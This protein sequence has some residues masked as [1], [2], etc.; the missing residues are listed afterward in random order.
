KLYSYFCLTRVTEKGTYGILTLC[1]FPIIEKAKYD[2]SFRNDI[3]PRGVSRI[4]AEIGGHGLLHVY[5]IHLG[6][7]VRERRHQ[8]RLMLSES[9]LLDQHRQDPKIIMGDFND[10]IVSVVHGK[11]RRHF[12]DIFNYLQ[13]KKRSTF[14]WRKI[15]MRLDH[16]YISEQF[17]PI[18][19]YVV[20]NKLTDVASDHYP[21][22]GILRLKDSMRSH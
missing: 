20:K 6:L 2:L 12:I 7:R 5:N 11:L 8:R 14:R 21:L 3:E 22:V 17:I 13:I 16:I 10:R 18:D 15:A 9:I 19:A 1:R 4:D